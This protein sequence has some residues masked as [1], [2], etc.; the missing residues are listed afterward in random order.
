MSGPVTCG[1][2]GA[3][4]PFSHIEAPDS[5]Q[6][7]ANSREGQLNDPAEPSLSCRY[8]AITSITR[9]FRS[10]FLGEVVLVIT[11]Q[12]LTG[13]MMGSIYHL[14]TAKGKPGCVLS[15]WHFP[16]QQLG[17]FIFGAPLHRQE[18]RGS[19]KAWLWQCQGCPHRQWQR[20]QTS[21]DP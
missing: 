9:C 4:N 7:K 19:G 1:L 11:Q 13:S 15:R 14:P 3:A 17:E 12:K 6:P 16:L 2:Q 21:R 18:H 8:I 10:R 20:V 5:V